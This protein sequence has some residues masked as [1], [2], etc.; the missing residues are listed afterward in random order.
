MSFNT[1]ILFITYKRYHTS[2]R[3]FNSIKKLKPRILY[4]ASNAPKNEREVDSVNKVR[5]IIKKINWKCKLVLIFHKKHLLVKDSI[6]ASIDFFFSKEEQ[7]IILEDD[8]LPS[9]Y[10]YFFCHKML[11][12]FKNNKLIQSISGSR[13]SAQTKNSNIY[14]SKYTHIWGW[15]TWRSRWKKYDSSIKFWPKLKKSKRFLN[16]NPEKNEFNYWKKIYDMTYEKKINTWDYAWQATAWNY[17][18]LCIIPPVSLTQNIGFGRDAEHTV[19]K[20]RFEKKKKE[21][22]ISYKIPKV[23]DRDIFK[24]YDV[25]LHFYKGKFLRFDKKV[26]FLIQFFFKDPTTFILKV[27]KKLLSNFMFRITSIVKLSF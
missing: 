18:Q 7:G 8:V 15:A 21:K 22:K 27:K 3:V 13:F 1:P 12:T 17:N 26:W 11:S 23:L 5:N 10:F 6:P 14:L 19:A 25:F 20:D 2:I 9:Q 16:L 24:D 4:F